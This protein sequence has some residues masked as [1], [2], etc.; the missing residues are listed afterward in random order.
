LVKETNKTKQVKKQAVLVV[1]THSDDGE[2][3]V[4]EGPVAVEEE[5]DCVLLVSTIVV[6][7]RA[8]EDELLVGGEL[9]QPGPDHH[10]RQ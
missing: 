1:V 6:K 8:G 10:T 3:L 4:N 9:H 7:V 5:L 2:V